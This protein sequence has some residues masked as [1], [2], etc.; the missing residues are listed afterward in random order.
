MNLTSRYEKKIEELTSQYKL[1]NDECHQAWMLLTSANEQLEQLRMDMDNKLFQAETLGKH[2][3]QNLFSVVF[4]C[5]FGIYL[6]IFHFL[7]EQAVE[8]QT[9]NFRVVSER[10]EH[11]KKLWVAAINDLEGKIKVIVYCFLL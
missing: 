1:K 6:I 8:R 5:N 9:D 10:Y 11:D 4:P 7:L 3:I 2:Q